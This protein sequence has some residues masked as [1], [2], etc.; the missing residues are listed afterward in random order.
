[1]KALLV[2]DIKK[3]YIKKYLKELIS[4]INQR[5]CKAN[6]VNELI[7][8]KG[9]VTYTSSFTIHRFSKLIR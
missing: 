8:Y 7:V 4:E 3:E 2:L 5:I 1:M 9:K 6:E